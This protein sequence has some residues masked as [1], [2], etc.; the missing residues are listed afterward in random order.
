MTEQVYCDACGYYTKGE[1]DD[2][3][4]ARVKD[5]EGNDIKV[6][7]H[8]QLE[9]L[10][11][12]AEGELI[13]SVDFICS[14]CHETINLLQDNILLAEGKFCHNEVSCLVAYLTK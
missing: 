4:E 10:Q 6:H 9:C 2:F 12:V 11:Q 1:D 7:V 8:K 5:S 3:I 14:G 13:F